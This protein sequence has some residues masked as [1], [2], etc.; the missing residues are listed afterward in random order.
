[1]LANPLEAA[2]RHGGFP[3]ARVTQAFLP[4]RITV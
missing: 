4:E 2:A 3:G 1:M